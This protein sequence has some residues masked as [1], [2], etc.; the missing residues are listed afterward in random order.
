MS[1]LKKDCLVCTGC[2]KEYP[3]DKIFP[4]CDNCQEPLEVKISLSQRFN[5]NRKISSESIL[6]HYAA[7]Y[8]FP[9]IDNQL[10]LQE[11]FTPLVKV[12]KLARLLEID[13]LYLKNETVNPTWSFKDRGTYVG[14]QHALSSGCN[15]IG[16][17]SSG[18]MA[19]SVAAYGARAGLKTII[20]VSANMPLEKLNPILIYQPILIRVQGD[21]GQMYYESLKIGQEQG[22][23]FLNSD[24]P[25]RVEGSKSI[26]FEIC[27]QLDYSVP[28]YVLIPTS[29][30]GNA[31]GILKGFLE[32][33][34]GGLIKKL[35]KIVCIQLAGCAPI[36]EAWIRNKDRI[37]PIQEPQAIDNAIANPFP[38][39]GNE[40]LR[41]LRKYEGSITTV[42]DNEALQGQLM[43][44]QEGIFAQP[45]AA[46]SVIA[47][48]KLKKEG[49]ISKKS[50]CVVL[51]TGA[52][53]KYTGILERHKFNVS[54]GT[55]PELNKIIRTRL[56]ELPL[57]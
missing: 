5:K 18:N 42:T 38:P 44:A 9:W 25:F 31:R 26:A 24:V 4:R 43:L 35:P 21:Y 50:H 6:E 53:I 1:T 55:L 34:E 20:L 17:L 16:T 39:S 22:I 49:I 45:A 10:S 56:K 52:G 32:F 37:T 8:P 27:E 29:S 3:L 51:V 54:T 12:D 13:N 15:Y 30:G 14:V 46:V 19:A 40:L 11:G 2:H 47:L 41:K 57:Y 48:Q 7:F 28:D 33:F 36:Y 23:Y